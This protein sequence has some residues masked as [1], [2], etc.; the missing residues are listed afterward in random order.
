LLSYFRFF[1][2]A[3]CDS[4]SLVYQPSTVN[5]I[6]EQDETKN[7]PFDYDNILNSYYNLKA[8]QNSIKQNII[9]K[10]K[11]NEYQM[12]LLVKNKKDPINIY[13]QIIKI[14]ELKMTMKCKDCFRLINSCD[15]VERV[16]GNSRYLIQLKAS[17]LIDDHT[18]NLKIVYNNSNFDLQNK[19]SNLFLPIANYLQSIL[20]KHLNEIDMITVPVNTFNPIIQKEDDN[21]RKEMTIEQHITAQ[22]RNKLK[23]KNYLNET[24]SSMNTS[25][26]STSILNNVS[27]T[28]F[29]DSF[30]NRV[31]VEVYKTIYDYL[32]YCILN[33]YFVFELEPSEIDEINNNNSYISL[34][35][36]NDTI[37]KLLL[38]FS[39][40]TSETCEQYKSIQTANCFRFT[41]TDEITDDHLL[42]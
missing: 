13:G 10:K 26:N 42:N 25:G 6:S 34:K 12:E 2:I 28:T 5:S 8:I 3:E 19:Q 24:N 20:T 18:S 17:F 38:S 21:Q 33:K 14:Y 30:S 37:K 7:Y 27:M 16:D 40:S 22:I 29:D 23:N 31:K 11:M 9:L 36:E 32:N 15:C 1:S 41:P 35:K 39:L 4:N